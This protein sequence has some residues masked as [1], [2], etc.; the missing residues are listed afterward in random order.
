MNT[1]ETE[2][3]EKYRL[4]RDKLIEKRNKL[5]DSTKKPILTKT[6][7]LQTHKH[8]TSLLS[9]YS[10]LPS[11]D[12]K[13]R[14][15]Y[16]QLTCPFM[17]VIKFNKEKQ[18]NGFIKIEITLKF[19]HCG[20]F[21][22]N[23]LINNESI[24][25]LKIIPGILTIEESNLIHTLI[26]QSVKCCDI[27]LFIFRMNSI[28]KMRETRNRIW[29]SIIDDIDSNIIDSIN[30]LSITKIQKQPNIL[31]INSPSTLNIQLYSG[32]TLS[33]TWIIKFQNTKRP[34]VSDF[35]VYANKQNITKLFKSL[36]KAK[37][38]KAA[39]LQILNII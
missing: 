2:L 33:I 37:D 4:Q 9:E 10:R 39:T 18:S 13:K 26:E 14:L 28:L 12:M 8:A 32:S 1:N 19:I 30:T 7:T 35:I 5:R 17:N 3:M 34:C 20:N 25:S 15:E 6:R 23:L 38:I 31:L 21:D 24:N 22:I 16:A 27:S 36:I 29:K 11:L